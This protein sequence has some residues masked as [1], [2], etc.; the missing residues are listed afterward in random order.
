MN[1]QA[2]AIQNLREEIKE[3]MD[4]V[5]SQMYRVKTALETMDKELAN[6][7]MS[8][9]K[10]VNAMD[11]NIDKACENILA[12]YNPLAMDLR[13]VLACLNINNQLERMGDHAESIAEY[14]LNGEIHQPFTEEVLK[15]IE[16]NTAFETSLSMIDDAIYSFLNEDTQ[17]AKWVFGKDLTLN[18]INKNSPIILTTFI[19]K[20]PENTR[21]YLYLFSIMKKLERIGDLAK[22]IAEETV[23]YVDAKVIR[24]KDEKYKIKN[25]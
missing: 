23:F 13:F 18:K 14:I 1:N 20:N 6:E 11:I 25:K 10:K 22:N 21:E 9:E 2:L 5:K 8:L 19:Q 16:F 12:L 3:M 7:I 4:A 15:A 17:I 24:H